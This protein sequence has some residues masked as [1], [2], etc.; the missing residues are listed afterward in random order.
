MKNHLLALVK[1]NSV[2]TEINSAYYPSGV[3]KSQ[4]ACLAGDTVG[5]VHLCRWQVTLADDTT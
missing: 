3:G 2:L 4:P 1:A 5:N